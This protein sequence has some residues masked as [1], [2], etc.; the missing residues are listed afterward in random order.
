MN[1]IKTD[2]LPYIYKKVPWTP[3]N[4]MLFRKPPLRETTMYLVT[5]QMHK[6]FS[7]NMFLLHLN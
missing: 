4:K 3:F 6:E 7:T 1:R 2:A 5:M